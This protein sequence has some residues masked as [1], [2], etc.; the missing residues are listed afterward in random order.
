MDIFSGLNVNQR[1]AVESTEGRIRLIAGAGSGKTKAL[2]HRYAYIVNELGIDPA[3]ILCLTFT[4]KAAQ[5]MRNRISGLVHRGN[6]NDFIC[7]IHGFCVKLLRKDIHRIGYPKTFTIIDEEDSKSYAKQ[8]MSELGIS[9]EDM[10]VKKFI[11][12]IRQNK[13]INRSYIDAYMYPD[14]IISEKDNQD[15]FVQY[16]LKQVKYFALDFDDLIYFALH[17]LDRYSDA[18]DYWQNQ[19]NYIMVDEV[20]DCNASDWQLI[21]TLSEKYNNLF[22]VG[23]PDQAI[24]EWRGSQPKR[25]IEFVSDRDITLNQNYRSTPNILNVANSIIINNK[26]RLKKDLFTLKPPS[27]I[28]THFHAKSEYEEASWISSQILKFRESGAKNSDFAILYRAS[29]LSRVIEQELL[30]KNIEYTIWGG[31]RFFERKE[32]KDAI[33]YLRLIDRDDDIA[34]MRISNVP[35]RKIGKVFMQRLTSIAEVEGTTFFQTL[36]NHINDEDFNKPM[37]RDFV[38]M[39]DYCR[40]QIEIISISDLLSYVLKESGLT[41]LLRRDGDEDRLE[42]ISEL[43]NSIKYYEEYNREDDVSL[44]NYLQDIALYTNADYS[45]ESDKVKLMTIHQAKGLEFPC[46]FVIGLSE[47]IFPN[48]RSIREFKKKGEEEERRLMYVAITR[49]EKM[50]YLSDSE[51]FNFATGMAKYPSRFLMEIKKGLF[52]SEGEMDDTIWKEAKKMAEFVDGETTDL[53]N[54]LD[55]FCEGEVVIHSKFGR[56]S[57]ISCDSSR[58]SYMVNF[59]NIGIRNVM[60]GYI[61]KIQTSNNSLPKSKLDRIKEKRLLSRTWFIINNTNRILKV[62][63][64]VKHRLYDYG[65]VIAINDKYWKV[66]FFDE[67]NTLLIDNNQK[68]DFIVSSETD[69]FYK[70]LNNGSYFYVKNI[71]ECDGTANFSG[72]YS[73]LGIFCENTLYSMEI[74]RMLKCTELEFKE[75]CSDWEQFCEYRSSK[76]N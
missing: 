72:V 70:S 58:E 49:A 9:R 31:V 69:V 11:D 38:D 42:N 27:Q 61:Q 48:M 5:E 55:I 23:D 8:I 76:D 35:S 7:T 68:L 34:F 21:Y 74:N 16:L 50:L 47:G 18:M 32:I 62:G 1:V 12:N 30:R 46:V 63:D 4:N 36:K 54:Q 25:F 66:F 37:V 29:Y 20:Q 53:N 57:I 60:P 6:Y 24:Y 51:G 44:T 19:F 2:A 71:I 26:E 45:R 52:I 59:S 65:K 3:N 39:I 67:E 15:V 73:T 41:M 40:S 17:I 43:L 14:C 22:I 28:I 10:T 56:G 75:H 33:S 64:Y 13:A